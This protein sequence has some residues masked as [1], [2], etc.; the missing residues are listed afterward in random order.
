MD[1]A[2]SHC[3]LVCT[4]ASTQHQEHHIHCVTVIQAIYDLDRPLCRSS[5]SF[6]GNIVEAELSSSI[7]F[8]SNWIIPSK[9]ALLT[10]IVYFD[11]AVTV[12]NPTQALVPPAYIGSHY[13]KL[14]NIPMFAYT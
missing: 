14:V 9:L 13:Q 8:N 5:I 1:D 10:N 11:N 4:A 7:T 6:Y 12:L 2:E 3:F